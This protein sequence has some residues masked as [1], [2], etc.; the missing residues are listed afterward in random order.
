VL[1][2]AKTDFMMN[3]LSKII[4]ERK[5]EKNYIAIVA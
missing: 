2:V 3:Y 1:L 5:I 4:K